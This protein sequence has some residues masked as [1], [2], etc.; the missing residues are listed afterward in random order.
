MEY[1][2]SEKYIIASGDVSLENE[3]NRNRNMWDQDTYTQTWNFVAV[4][5][6][7]QTIPGTDIPYIS[8]IGNVAMEAM[9]A[10]VHHD[11][12]DANLLVQCALL[13]DVIEDTNIGYKQITKR[14]GIEIVLYSRLS[15]FFCRGII[16][17]VSS[18]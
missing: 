9:A 1:S 4:A 5:H 11:T 2:Y 14:F 15:E 8:H 7:G 3:K 12:C 16:I 6:N 13:H 17:I 18:E 10:I